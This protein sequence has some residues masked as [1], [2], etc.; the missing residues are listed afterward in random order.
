MH[1]LQY[2]YVHAYSSSGSTPF[3]YFALD[4]ACLSRGKGEGDKHITE[5][6]DAAIGRYGGFFGPF[7]NLTLADHLESLAAG[8]GRSSAPHSVL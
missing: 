8:G 4:C 7:L 1:V 5:A 2:V 3:W 6:C